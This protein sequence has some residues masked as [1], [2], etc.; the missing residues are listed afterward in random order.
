MIFIKKR[1]IRNSENRLSK[2]GCH[3]NVKVNRQGLAPGLAIPNCSLINFSHQVIKFNA[4]TLLLLKSYKRPKSVRAESAP[5][6]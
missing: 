6:V 4:F 3:G 2:S 5:P 1:E